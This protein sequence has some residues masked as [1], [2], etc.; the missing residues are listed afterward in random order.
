[1]NRLN[2]LGRQ[3]GLALVEAI[4]GW[5]VTT[6]QFPGERR[7][8]ETGEPLIRHPGMAA[9]CQWPPVSGHAR[10]RPGDAT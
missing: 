2:A 9:T 3:A 6:I 1:M 8:P 5:G 4:K 7:N 10:D